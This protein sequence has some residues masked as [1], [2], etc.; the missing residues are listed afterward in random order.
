MLMLVRTVLKRISGMVLSGTDGSDYA[1]CTLCKVQFSVRHGGANDV[2]ITSALRSI[3]R[4]C[5]D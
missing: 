1:Y 4:V 3:Y 2:L 5:K